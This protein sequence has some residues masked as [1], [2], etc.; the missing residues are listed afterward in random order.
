MRKVFT[1]VLLITI[2]V[3]LSLG[4]SS[5]YLTY[6]SV[7]KD[8][9]GNLL[10]NA[11]VGVRIGV[12]QSSTSGTI[13]YQETHSATT[14]SN[15]L[16]TIAIG[17][18][19][20]STGTWASIDWSAGPYF[21]SSEID[22]D[23][24]T[25]YS[26]S[27]TTQVL[28]VPFALYAKKAGE[29][30][31]VPTKLSELEN[32]A[33]YL[34]SHKDTSNV[35]ELQV[36]SISN[37]TIYLTDGEYAVLPKTFSGSYN[38][39]TDLPEHLDTDSTDDFSGDF[40]DLFNVP[41]SVGFSGLWSD[42]A[43]TPT[44]IE[45]YGITDAFN[46]QWSSLEGIPLTIDFDS[47]DNFSGSFDE[48]SDVPTVITDLIGG[49]FSFEDL[50]ETPTSL[51]GYG[52]T[53]EIFD[54]Q[55]S[56]LEGIP[57]TIDFDS[58][59]NF[60]GSFDELSDVP[61][62]ITDL[63]GGDFSFGD[64]SETPTSLA[65]YGITDEIFDGQWSSL[66]GIPL[67]IDFDS[68]D[69]FS[70]SFGEL[71]DVPTVITDLIGGDFSFEDLS[72]T[73]TSLAGYGITDEIFDGQW[74]SLEGIP[75]T[76]DLDSTDNFSGHW[77]DLI[78]V[79]S[80]LDLIGGA[81]E[82]SWD[83]LVDIPENLDLD[84]TNDFSGSWSDLTGIPETIDFD[85]TDNFTGNWSDLQGI[86]EDLDLDINDDFDGEWNSLNGRPE[87][88]DL[89]YTDDFSGNWSDLVGIP[90]T[91]D[92]DSTDNF[93]G[94]YNS[95]SNLPNLFSGNWSDLNGM[96]TYLDT[97]YRDDFDGDWADLNGVPQYL[98][99]DYRND[100]SGNYNDLSNLPTTIAFKAYFPRLTAADAGKG[101]V[102][103]NPIY[104]T[105][106]DALKENIYTV[107]EDGY[108][109][110][111]F[112]VRSSGGPI[113]LE[114]MVDGEARGFHSYGGG[115]ETVNMSSTFMIPL[116]RGQRLTVEFSQSGEGQVNAGN[117]TQ[118]ISGFSGFLMR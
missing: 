115:S 56:S 35:N 12:I 57:L 58:T 17:S 79:P 99:T 38:D 77:D 27:N 40:N 81:D 33:G 22:P 74:S 102:T 21:I 85:S 87:L 94:D 2:L 113:Q 41:P 89:D 109:S 103:L 42:L 93:N 1:S 25:S 8:S 6:Q 100:F 75:V 39:L 48:L 49:D 78:G 66:E 116:V 101:A 55:W 45:G 97:D 52:I 34:T 67:T 32:D 118:D 82:V 29:V 46:G 111:V 92:F 91:I 88:L 117:A 16:M 31:G 83:A 13:I 9:E 4:Q 54:G 69:N 60:T 112:H 26:I 64:L 114:L 10:N 15:G 62:V 20:A 108:Y 36:L 19:S 84:Y 18:G 59:D 68:T 80:L 47:T 24:G 110:L 107:P 11:A 30:D 70:G 105:A 96:P 14:N 71:S 72:E 3:R 98:D 90:E 61:T 73:P 28:S 104:D 23:G 7:I 95:L 76:I 53:D 43:E 50:S 5:D 65:G 106:E 63:I 37:D 86:P 44:T 51:A